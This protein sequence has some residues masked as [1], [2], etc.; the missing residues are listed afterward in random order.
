MPLH[1][2]RQLRKQLSV[3]QSLCLVRCVCACVCV[4]NGWGGGRCGVELFLSEGGAGSSCALAPPP[5]R[6][7]AGEMEEARAR[8]PS[9]SRRPQPCGLGA[10]DVSGLRSGAQ[11]PKKRGLRRSWAGG[12]LR[13]HWRL[14]ERR[15]HF[16]RA[17]HLLLLQQA[18][19][20]HSPALDTGL[21]ERNTCQKRHA[22]RGEGSASH[23]TRG[24]ME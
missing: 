11:Q 16:R 4:G 17:R 9:R 10:A 13:P 18:S 6:A 15:A 7:S 5:P 1:E 23:H 21:R 20:W 2:F 8:A 3:R 19:H 14:H 24:E 22:E 12:S